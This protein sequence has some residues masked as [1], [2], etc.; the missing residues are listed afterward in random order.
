MLF[1]LVHGLSILFPPP[2]P[3]THTRCVQGSVILWNTKRYISKVFLFVLI[4]LAT[5]LLSIITWAK[6]L[7]WS[8]VITT[9]QIFNKMGVWC[10]SFS[11]FAVSRNCS[12]KN[13]HSLKSAW[14]TTH[15]TSAM[16]C[17]SEWIRKLKKSNQAWIILKGIIE[18]Q[19]D[20]TDQTKASST[21][22]FHD[23]G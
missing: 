4:F 11:F 8:H 18:G 17:I 16:W 1:F 22:G 23:H 15:F 20:V 6:Q 5:I 3:H 2:P 10:W 9:V 14:I 21:P 12:P 7:I 19:S 13:T